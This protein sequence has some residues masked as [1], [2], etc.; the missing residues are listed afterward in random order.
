MV[1]V[2]VGAVVAV[3]VSSS[4]NRIV[5][6]NS[7]SNRYNVMRNRHLTSLYII[8]TLILGR[9]LLPLLY[10][11]PLI[12]DIIVGNYRSSSFL[13]HFTVLYHYLIFNRNE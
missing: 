7:S 13:S 10:Y 5:V 8:I 11:F 9:L 2:V 4:S 12:R 1:V 6:S 3:A